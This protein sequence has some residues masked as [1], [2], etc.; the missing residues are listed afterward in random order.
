MSQGMD[1]IYDFAIVGAG[2]AGASVAARLAG[3]A[4]VLILE[5]EP[6]PGYHSTGR[7]AALY[8]A[9][10]GNDTITAITRA[11]RAHFDRPPPGFCEH[12]LLVPR[13]V[14]YAGTADD[15]EAVAGLCQSPLAR[16]LTTAEA[17]QLVPVLNEAAAQECAYEP[18]AFD[19]DVNELHQGFLRMARSAGA[20]LA[21]NAGLQRLERKP[22]LWTLVTAAG[23][24]QARVLVNAAGAW[25]DSVAVLAGARPLGLQPLLR[26]ALI[27]DSPG[28]DSARWPLVVGADE[29][30]YFKPD[31]GML[32][33]SL[34]DEKPS[35]PCDAQ[36]D[37]LDIAVCVDRI[38]SRTTLRIKR[39]VRSW[40]GLRTFAPDRTPIVGYDPAV[41]RFF[42][43][44]GQGGYGVQTSP[45]LS[46]IAA[47][48]AL[49]KDI[50]AYILDEGFVPASI[51]PSRFS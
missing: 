23:E 22:G 28:P 33:A 3:S 47:S 8:S 38:E 15:A 45:A 21:N 25:A 31:A 49:R 40:A 46:D 26:T 10:Y 32:L 5:R 41:E 29:S 43:L 18:D 39:V 50:P 17:L 19:I 30:Y 16:R 20:R 44:A 4:R 51:S 13:G 2:I 6:A 37:D 27:I 24:F 1:H 42:W 36:P 48:L 9:L 12:P 35:E 7:S 34:A 11:S 14:L